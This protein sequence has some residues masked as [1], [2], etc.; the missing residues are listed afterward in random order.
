MDTITI[1]IYLEGRM[2]WGHDIPAKDI[3]GNPTIV[4]EQPNLESAYGKAKSRTEYTIR[5][6]PA[7]PYMAVKDHK[8][9]PNK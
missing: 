6:S 5:T 4:V 9:V 8:M 2:V 1:Q 7:G 3:E